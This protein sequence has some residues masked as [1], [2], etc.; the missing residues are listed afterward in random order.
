ML[1]LN[2]NYDP[3]WQVMGSESLSL[4]EVD[5][6][7]GINLRKGRRVVEL[8]YR[9]KTFFVGAAVSALTL[10]LIAYVFRAPRRAGAEP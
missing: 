9:P 6:V 7:I 2:I 10:L 8:A 1:K 5:G 3:G 4:A